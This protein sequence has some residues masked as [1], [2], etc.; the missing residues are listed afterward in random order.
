VSF[1]LARSSSPII[2]VLAAR[3]RSEISRRRMPK[4]R[5][6]EARSRPGSRGVVACRLAK[7]PGKEGLG[8]VTEEPCPL[9][10]ARAKETHRAWQ[11]QGAYQLGCWAPLPDDTYI[12]I[13]G[14]GNTSAPSV[15][16]EMFPRALLHADGSGTITEPDNGSK[17]FMGKVSAQH[18]QEFFKHLHERP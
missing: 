16:W 2:V 6:C 7:P 8:T 11:G 10:L 9:P 17:T 18:A 14:N 3:R 1:P 4:P 13:D 15:L 12:F 5:A